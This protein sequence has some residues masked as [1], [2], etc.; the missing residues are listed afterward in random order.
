MVSIHIF[1]RAMVS[2]GCYI[3]TFFFEIQFI[4]GCG[5]FFEGS[6]EQMYQSLIVTLGSLPKSTRVYCGHEVQSLFSVSL[7][8]NLNASGPLNLYGGC[9]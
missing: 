7:R 2:F 6:A 9:I 3:I 4:A 8:R 5:K 1:L